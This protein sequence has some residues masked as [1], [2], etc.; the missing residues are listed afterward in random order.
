[1]KK[2]A[3]ILISL[4][5][6][7]TS[8]A[9]AQAFPTVR[10]P[11]HV[12]TSQVEQVRYDGQRRHYRNGNRH[13]WR[14]DRRHYRRD[15]YRNGHDRRYYRR[16]GRNGAAAIIGGIAAGAIIGGALN[17]RN[18]YNSSCASRYRSYRASDNTYQPYNGP[19]RQCR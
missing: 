15:Y 8:F 18:S 9:P 1:M 10:T 2:I 5:T 12:S 6:A 19:R 17:S 14:G 4:I 11:A 3:I 16:H 13:G 7:L